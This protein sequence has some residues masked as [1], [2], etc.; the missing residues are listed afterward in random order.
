M[1]STRPTS[2]AETN[3]KCSR[4]LP[5]STQVSSVFRLLSRSLSGWDA[6][7]SSSTMPIYTLTHPLSLVLVVMMRSEEFKTS[8]YILMLI[9]YLSLC[10]CRAVDV[11]LSAVPLVL[12]VFQTLL[13]SLFVSLLLG[14]SSQS[15]EMSCVC[16]AV[17]D[18]GTIARANSSPRGGR[19]NVRIMPWRGT[20]PPHTVADCTHCCCSVSNCC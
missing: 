7:Y 16:W 1:P 3:T 17:A 5:K 4:T 12:S 20:A 10:C 9:L 15:L 11:S 13:L 14:N 2:L 8:R 6:E 18:E 19:D